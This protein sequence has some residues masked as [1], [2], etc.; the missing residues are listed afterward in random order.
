MHRGAP[1]SHKLQAWEIKQESGIFTLVLYNL[2]ASLASVEVQLTILTLYR[3]TQKGEVWT[4]DIESGSQ[5]K[6]IRYWEIIM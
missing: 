5:T 2:G 3:Q 1:L 4:I 6:N